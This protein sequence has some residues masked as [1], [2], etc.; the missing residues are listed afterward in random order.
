MKNPPEQTIQRIGEEQPQQEWIQAIKNNTLPGSNFD[1]A[2]R[3]TEMVLV[4]SMAQRFGTKI[5]YN[6][7]KM[8]VKNRPD[9]DA[10]IKEP[11]REGWSYGEDLWK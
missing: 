3:L 7:K 1:Y 5:K 4:G 8:K 9:L 6:E 2:A 10:Y 11:V